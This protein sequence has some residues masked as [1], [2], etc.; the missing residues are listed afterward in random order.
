MAQIEREKSPVS[1]QVA[2]RATAPASRA[3]QVRI[4]PPDT[5]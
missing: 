2:A 1:A 4:H 3:V 5:C